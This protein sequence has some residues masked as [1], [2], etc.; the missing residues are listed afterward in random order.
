[1]KSF[2]TAFFF[3]G[4]VSMTSENGLAQVDSGHLVVFNM[5]YANPGM[6]DDV[7]ETRLYASVVRDRL[8]LPRGRVLRRINDVDGLPEVMWECEFPDIAAHD[9]DM[10]ARGASDAFEGV[11]DRMR[12]LIHRFERTLWQVKDP[13]SPITLTKAGLATTAQP[14]GGL[15]VTNWYY[16]K[17]DQKSAVLSHRIHASDV[18]RQLGHPGGRVLDRV[19]DSA[20]E[21]PEVIWQMDYAS[22]EARQKD[23]EAIGSTAEFKKVMDRM[24]TLVR[25]FD[26]GVWEIQEPLGPEAELP[27]P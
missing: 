4:L 16:A 5:Y 14:P 27:T 21:V 13:L 1:M 15:V 18:R 20:G 17:P 9:R 26:R 25:D 2:C 24:T 12:T 11:R 19:V 8:G 22:P 6:A 7:L 10:D 23:G 3:L